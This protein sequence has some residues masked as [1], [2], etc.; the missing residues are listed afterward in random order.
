MKKNTMIKATILF[1][2]IFVSSAILLTTNSYQNSIID[3]N[4][5][6]SNLEAILSN[7]WEIVE[8]EENTIPQNYEGKPVCLYIKIADTDTI[9]NISERNKHNEIEGSY[10]PFWYIWFAPS[11]WRG[12]IPPQHGQ[13]W[14]PAVNYTKNY[15]IYYGGGDPTYKIN[16]IIIK[17]N[18]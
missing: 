3:K 18:E 15:Q 8:I 5:I 9:L 2:F 17:F 12:S 7:G 16:E 14:T 11:N 10:H 13:Y 6:I 1:I 4:V